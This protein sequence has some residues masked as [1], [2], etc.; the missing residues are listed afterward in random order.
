[1]RLTYLILMYLVNFGLLAQSSKSVSKLVAEQITTALET[2]YL[3]NEIIMLGE[4]NHSTSEHFQTAFLVIK[5]Q[6]EENDYKV[7]M[8]ESSFLDSYLSVRK[9]NQF[10]IE[11]I[12]P[13]Y[14][15]SQE[16]Q[17]L[18]GI[19]KSFS[20]LGFD[21]QFDLNSADVTFLSNYFGLSEGQNEIFVSGLD[22]DF[23][24]TDEFNKLMQSLINDS[25]DSLDIR[26]LENILQAYSFEQWS[27]G[28]VGDWLPK[29]GNRRDK[30][31]AENIKF[32]YNYFDKVK[33]LALGASTHFASSFE[34]LD[35]E[36]LRA[37]ISTGSYLK[38][39]IA[40]KSI[41]NPIVNFAFTSS[42]GWKRPATTYN[43]EGVVSDQHTV[44]ANLISKKKDF[45]ILK[46]DDSIINSHAIGGKAISG[47]F[48]PVWDYL[49]IFKNATGISRLKE[50]GQSVKLD[51]RKKIRL[52]DSTSLNPIPHAHIY[53]ERVKEGTSA[54]QE[55]LFTLLMKDEY[56]GQ[57]V[58]ISSIGYK[59]KVLLYEDLITTDTILLR[60]Q[61][62]LLQE[63]D[64]QAKLETPYALMKQII[65]NTQNISLKDHIHYYNTQSEVYNDKDTLKVATINEVILF[66]K[67]SFSVNIKGVKPFDSLAF[68]KL[69]FYASYPWRGLLNS[70]Y[71]FLPLFQEKQLQTFQLKFDSVNSDFTKVHFN[72]K[73]LSKKVVGFKDV[74]QYSG[75]IYIKEDL[76][77]KIILKI[78][79]K[80]GDYL[81]IE[82][83]FRAIDS[84]L[85]P[86]LIKENSVVNGVTVK[87]L[88]NWVKSNIFS[89]QSL[90]MNH[91]LLSLEQSP[92]VFKSYN[93]FIND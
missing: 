17:I 46:L 63:V 21:M 8:T 1:M 13:A 2:K 64:V 49:I 48:Q 84:E 39:Y 41:K 73:I 6:I 52:L 30:V 78:K 37:Y 67:E 60:S 82:S 43:K 50:E 22:F 70:H 19:N 69:G 44:E 11:T 34:T 35:N 53:V 45:E 16:Y 90:K 23:S 86:V 7:L 40:E 51:I 42:Q 29:Y 26:A 10:A 18:K 66:D 15:L 54:N 25:E 4:Q 47:N 24:V 93:E 57:E 75:S 59:R 27:Q 12:M 74:V 58:V 62:L 55:G 76:P 14:R 5:E 20:H 85:T 72:S 33:F 28:K 88:S 92:Q 89:G 31:M 77:S 56:K 61:T 36:D 83:H 3:G 81:N 79:F 68:S 71:R 91:D 80:S 65:K 38:R 32:W 87:N 9:N